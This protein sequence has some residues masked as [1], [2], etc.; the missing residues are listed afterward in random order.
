MTLEDLRKD[1][2]G[3]FLATGA[4]VQP[5]IG[6]KGEALTKSGLEFLTNVSLGVKEIPKRRVL[7]IGG[8][9][10][11]V[12]VGITAL[13]LGAQEVVLACLEC[14]EEM[15]A[16]EEEIEQALEEGIKLMP[17][18]GPIR[19]LE[20]DG[21][22]TGVELRRC[23]SVFDENACFA[24]TFDDSDTETVETDQVL[25]A[26]GQMTDLSFLGSKSPLHT[27]GGLI[28]VNLDTQQTN[29][30]GIFAGGDVTSS[31][32]TVVEAIAAGRRAAA[33]MDQ[34]LRG[35]EVRGEDREER[36]AE[37]LLQFNTKCLTRN[38][39]VEMPRIPAGE[40][41]VETEETLG[42]S[43]EA[44]EEEANRCF[45]CGC[46]A[47]CPSDVAPALIAL[48]AKIKTTKRTVAAEEFFTAATMKS[49]VLDPSEL[50]TEI[51][52]PAP[53]RGSKQ[54]F[55]KYRLRKAIDFPIVAVAAVIG[56]KAGK[57]NAARIALGAV[58]PIP[59]R[60]KKVEAFLVGK[61]IDGEVAETAADMAVEGVLPLGRNRYKV[62]ITR[63]LVRR[64][65]LAAA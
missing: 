21:Q 35:G 57:V 62:Q 28:M 41:S 16:F 58:A 54:V 64:A 46:V 7:V 24:P 11:A 31:R 12:D 1:F 17:S 23:T 51:Q 6:T 22:V 45:N 52:I 48:D 61:K 15:P 49:T 29:V 55:L 5:S 53:K 44:V 20:T 10:V 36:G 4:W 14:R 40:R 2:D 18:W 56:M 30:P 3:V 32:G 19:V 42:F 59:L 63:A 25:M 33:S 60:T 65:I 26:V 9:S 43:S 39:R 8:G 37:A 34:Y 38:S 13:R 27:D 47:V 50:V